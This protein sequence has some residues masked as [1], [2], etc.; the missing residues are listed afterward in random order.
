M[1]EQPAYSENLMHNQ[2]LGTIAKLDYWTGLLSLNVAIHSVT[3][4]P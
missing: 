3:S 4:T 2:Q 1:H